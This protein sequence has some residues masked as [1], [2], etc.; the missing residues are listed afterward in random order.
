MADKTEQV[1]VGSAGDPFVFE[2]VSGPVS[3]RLDDFAHRSETVSLEQVDC[4]CDICGCF[5][6]AGG[7][8]CAIAIA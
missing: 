2:P 5:C 6:S 4:G 1:P 3:S 8:N 7:C